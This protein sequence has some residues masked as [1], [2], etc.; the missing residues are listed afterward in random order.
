MSP[1]GTVASVGEAEAGGVEVGVGKVGVEVVA[2]VSELAG[3]D[4]FEVEVNVRVVVA[5]V[6]VEV[7][8]VVLEAVEIVE[9]DVNMSSCTEVKEGV[10]VAV[11]LVAV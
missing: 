8:V 9:V 5:V 10:D 1:V 11:V 4:E 7:V 6:E 2:D 3:E